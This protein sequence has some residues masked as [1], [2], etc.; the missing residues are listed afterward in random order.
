MT[1]S[2]ADHPASAPS[3]DDCPDPFGPYADYRVA[4][5]VAEEKA[6]LYTA[7][8]ALLD[9]EYKKLDGAQGRYETD[10][11]AQKNAWE[12]LKCR[13]KRIAE[14]LDHTLDGKTRQQLSDCWNKIS[15]ETDAATAPTNCTEIDNLSCDKIENLLKA[16]PSADDVT[17]LRQQA[18][19]ADTCVAQSDVAFDELAG[20]PEAMAAQVTALTTRVTKLDQDLAA[21]T[22]DPRRSY[23]QYLDIHRA[24]CQFEGQLTTA[25]KYACK[26][27]AAFVALLKTHRTAICLKAAIHAIDKRAEIEAEAKTAKAGTLVDLVLECASDEP[28]G[29]DGPTPPDGGDQSCE[30]GQKEQEPPKEAAHA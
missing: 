29:G 13:L 16:G 15:R 12:D 24:F 18:I 14:T 22:S 1:E 8:A 19:L 11:A 5:S 28:A 9:P 10:W 23:V 3:K 2:T 6:S 27:K 26:L 4:V 21:P 30:P 25:A 17:K 20:F 7:D